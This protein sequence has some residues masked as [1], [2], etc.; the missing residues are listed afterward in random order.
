VQQQYLKAYARI[1]ERKN[2]PGLKIVA[3]EKAHG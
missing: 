2:N 1:A 3:K